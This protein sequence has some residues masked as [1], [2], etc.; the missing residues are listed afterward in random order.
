MSLAITADGA[1]APGYC[2]VSLPVPLDQP[3][4]HMLRN[5]SFGIINYVRV[6][7]TIGFFVLALA[8]L[9]K[10][11]PT[12]N[13]QVVDTQTSQREYTQY[14]PGTPARSTTNCDSNA[15]VYGAGGGTA[16]PTGRQ[17]AQLQRPPEERP[18]R[19]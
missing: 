12:L 13:I 4:T 8:L 18:A 14:I 3:F 7:L 5:R 1:A 17:I 16:T 19:L 6:A 9:A 11:K 15:T 10:D 2:D